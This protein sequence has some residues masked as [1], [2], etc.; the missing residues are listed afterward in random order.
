MHDRRLFLLESQRDELTDG[1]STLLHL[2]ELTRGKSAILTD[3]ITE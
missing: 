1:Q 3:L 2:A